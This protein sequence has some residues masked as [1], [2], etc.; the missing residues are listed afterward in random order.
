MPVLIPI[1][2]GAAFTATL[3]AAAVGVAI[4]AG[5]VILGQLLKPKTAA[6][7]VTRLQTTLDPNAYKVIVLGRTVCGADERYWEV[8]GAHGYDQVVTCA[9]H[10][11]TSFQECFIEGNL[12]TFSGNTCTGVI[13]SA[14]VTHS[15]I[16]SGGALKKYN[17][18]LGVS[19]SSPYG[20]TV[21]AGSLWGSS[22][23]MTGLPS[24]LLK[25]VYSQSKLPNGIPNRIAQVVEGS[26]VYD[27][28]RD[29]TNGGSGAHR[30]NDNSTWE[31]S[32]L[33]SNGVPIGRNNALQMLRYQLGWHILNTVTSLQVLVDGKGVLP[34]DLNYPNWISAANICE[35]E[36]YY[37]D[38]VLSTGDTHQN[39]ETII[40]AG[41]G[42]VLLDT[43]G[44]WS[45]YPATNDT[46]SI[47]V[48]L[49]EDDI[50][51]AVGW[52]PKDNLANL[53]NQ[54]TG[55]FIDTSQT[56]TYQ[57][58][59][60]PTVSD[61]TYIAQDNSIVRTQTLDFSNVQDPA[62]AQKLAR[63]ALNKNRVTGVF[64][65]T[66]NYKILQAELYNC[67]TLT[68]PPLGWVSKLF[69]ITSMG[70][71]PMGGI[72]A[73]LQ[74][75]FAAIYTGGTVNTYT[76]P[77]AGAKYDPTQQVPVTSLAAT[78]VSIVGAGGTIV[79]ALEISWATPPA[80]VK[81]TEIYYQ[82]VGASTWTLTATPTGDISD[83]VIS[84]V[85]PNTDYEIQART[86]SI[87]NVPGAYFTTTVFSGT[88]LTNPVSSISGLAPAAIDTSIQP[89][90]TVNLTFHQPDD[91]TTHQYVGSPP[92]YTAGTYV[93]PNGAYWIN[94]S[95]GSTSSRY[96]GSWIRAITPGAYSDGDVIQIL[97]G[98]G[99]FVF[100]G[101]YNLT[102]CDLL[103]DGGDGGNY[104]ANFHPPA[105][106]HFGGQGE[107]RTYTGLSVTPG[108]TSITYNLGA[109][110]TDGPI[111]ITGTNI[112]DGADSAIT[113]PAITAKKGLQASS[114][115]GGAGGTGG[116]GGAGTA[117]T[118]GGGSGD[119]G[120][121][122]LIA[123]T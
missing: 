33:D 18:L 61:A 49:S 37:T 107:R 52:D 81:A 38:C 40:S 111:A 79:D 58:Q 55:N 19:G 47:A 84:P 59:P 3:I 83:I 46:A 114:G 1:A 54:Y 45:Y 90:A 120:K 86:I 76:S 115:A 105:I 44:V 51:D 48:T 77:S 80:N 98:S 75:E 65:S 15:G 110:G 99:T 43:G 91:P 39:N 6:T 42:A 103:V 88:T 7:S 29:S 70:I 87:N 2:I 17:S 22:Q 20:V 68:F 10:K 85:Q 23:S 71:D 60:Y 106:A 35:S 12:L 69:R 73:T 100:P 4:I 122:T 94:S 112:S 97:Y 104:W 8:Y 11:L 93:V 92:T 5:V 101:T 118:T 26:P 13:D 119:P 16:Y 9:G 102:H 36:G 32:P 66:F 123:R 121:L 95:T 109:A 63:I 27:P 41:A 67:V 113:S 56:S 62:L 72:S 64:T 14:G 82:I 74:E 57:P 25:W 117:G 31:Y 21:G 53:Y 89:G 24:Y 78:A 34:E 108:T 96:G 50:I 30:P 28:R 116:S